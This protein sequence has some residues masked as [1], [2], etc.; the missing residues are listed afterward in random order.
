MNDQ[1]FIDL[2]STLTK[3]DLNKMEH[4][5]MDTPDLPKSIISDKEKQ[6]RDILIESPLKEETWDKLLSHDG[7]TG[8]INNFLFDYSFRSFYTKHIA[9]T[10]ITKELLDKLVNIFKGKKVLDA[11]CGMGYLSKLLS[12]RGIDITAVDNKTYLH[13]HKE[14]IYDKIIDGDY[15]DLDPT[16]FD[17]IILSWPSM[18][19]TTDLPFINRFT[20]KQTLVHIGE[21]GGCTGSSDF[22]SAIFYED[23]W[24]DVTPEGIHIKSFFGIHDNINFLKKKEIN[25]VS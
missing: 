15:S 18:D 14:D 5:D 10:I 22:N 17:Y 25:H 7:I 13:V 9:W 16:E 21:H 19:S 4:L 6:M 23:I 8:S 1:K 11:G 20:D 12:D 3:E 2:I 24:E